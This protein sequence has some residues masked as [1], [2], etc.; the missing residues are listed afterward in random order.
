LGHGEQLEGGTDDTEDAEDDD[1]GPST[2]PAPAMP[3]TEEDAAEQVWHEEDELHDARGI[4]ERDGG[5]LS[6]SAYLTLERSGSN[7][8]DSSA[9]RYLTRVRFWFENV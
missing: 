5:H 7:S 3:L 2:A 6:L 8:Q 4:A 1:D 9:S